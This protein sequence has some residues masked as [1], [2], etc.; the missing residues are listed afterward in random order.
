[1]KY[2]PRLEVILK[3]VNLN[4]PSFRM[5][6][7]ETYV[8]SSSSFDCEGG[9]GSPGSQVTQNSVPCPVQL[10]AFGIEWKVYTILCQSYSVKLDV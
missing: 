7:C 5:I 1:M 9:V 6:Y 4:I 2:T 8:F 10:K 3:E